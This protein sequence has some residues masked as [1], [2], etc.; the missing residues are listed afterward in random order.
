MYCGD[1]LVTRYMP[2]LFAGTLQWPLVSVPTPSARSHWRHPGVAHVSLCSISPHHCNPDNII[3]GC[4]L[5]DH[6]KY[7]I[8][9]YLNVVSIDKIWGQCIT[10][11]LWWE[12]NMRMCGYKN[13]NALLIKHF[14]LTITYLYLE[15]EMIHL[16][17]QLGCLQAHWRETVM[18]RIWINH[19]H[20]TWCKIYANFKLFMQLLQ[21]FNT[22]M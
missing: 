10:G 17:H 14:K 5:A 4:V 16:S 12:L 9:A 15:L 11:I 13:D 3:Y 22:T 21:V 2:H 7:G 18:K 20:L 8:I 1:N 6:T 19:T